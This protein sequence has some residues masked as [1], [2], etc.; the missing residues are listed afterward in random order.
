MVFIAFV[1]YDLRRTVPL[2]RTLQSISEWTWALSGLSLVFYCAY[3]GR[4]S[5]S[6]S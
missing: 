6:A 1:N 2:L 3:L 5:S 4:Q